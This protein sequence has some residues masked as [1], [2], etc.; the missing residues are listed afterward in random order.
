MSLEIPRGWGGGGQMP[1]F[2]KELSMKLNWNIQGVRGEKPS[3]EGKNHLWGRYGY[4]L[5]PHNGLSKV[6]FSVF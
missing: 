2:L 4:F 5:E 3:I 1:K 6:M